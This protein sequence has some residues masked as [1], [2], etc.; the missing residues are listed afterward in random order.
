LWVWNL[1]FDSAAL[2]WWAR[3]RLGLEFEWDLIV[4]VEGRRL[5]RS[6]HG[7]RLTK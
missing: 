4:R 5:L 2:L 7:N 6:V 1:L 3:V